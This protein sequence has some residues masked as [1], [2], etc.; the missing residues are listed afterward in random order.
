MDQDLKQYLDDKFA[1]MVSNF[2]QMDSKF[3][4][5]DSKLAQMGSKF[6]RADERFATKE[7]LERVETALLTAFH[8]WA[9]PAE[10]RAKTHAAALR[11]IDAELEALDDRA[12]KIEGSKPS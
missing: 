12:K 7:D 9:A 11:A 10:M 4:Q 3:A 8:K 1:Q 6:A 5:M 2:A